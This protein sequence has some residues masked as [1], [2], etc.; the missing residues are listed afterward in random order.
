MKIVVRF[1]VLTAVVIKLPLGVL[2]RVVLWK[3][4]DVSE[5]LTAFITTVSTP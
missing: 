3:F 1:E 5:F 2:R 4:T